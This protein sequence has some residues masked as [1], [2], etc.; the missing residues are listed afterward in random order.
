M[1][2]RIVPLR[3]LIIGAACLVV[4][5]G[6]GAPVASAQQPQD[7]VAVWAQR[8]R[9][10]TPTEKALAVDAL[11]E[12]PAAAL[13]ADVGRALVDELNRVAVAIRTGIAGATPDS[14]DDHGN[15][16]ASVAT[17]VA[18]LDTPEASLALVPAIG[19]SRGIQRRVARRGDLVVAPLVAATRVPTDQ[20]DALETLGLV[21]FWA[22]STNAPLS[23]VSRS[24]ILTTWLAAVQQDTGS[25]LLGV[26]GAVEMAG[27]PSLTPLLVVGTI[28]ASRAGAFGQYVLST[29]IQPA[30]DTLQDR[31]A[32]QSGLDLL[33]DTQRLAEAL[34]AGAEG[35]RRGLCESVSNELEVGARHLR[36][37]RPGPARNVLGDVFEACRRA[38]EKDVISDTEFALLTGS[39][40]ALLARP[41]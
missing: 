1:I 24:Q 38:R 4:A 12:V 13:S 28:T 32:T 37:G 21:W 29:V 15:Y 40:G 26:A 17:L 18:R 30:L 19:I 2:L 3:N 23:V 35:N 14:A 5:V 7:S 36:E 22:D 33:R 9:T 34:C 11:L 25:A 31:Q 39:L 20:V 8:I 27:D 41:W 16:F 6:M 10:G